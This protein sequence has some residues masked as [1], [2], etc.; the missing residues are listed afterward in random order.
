MTHLPLDSRDIQ[1]I[2]GIAAGYK[3]KELPPIVGLSI[4]TIE[5]RKSKIAD[6]L[7]QGKPTRRELIMAA[8]KF[9]LL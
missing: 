1:I 9:G 5:K 3:M 7:C 4:S 8:N 6:M 2:K